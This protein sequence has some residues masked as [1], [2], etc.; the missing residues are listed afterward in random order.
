MESSGRPERRVPRPDD[1]EGGFAQRAARPV[2]GARAVVGVG[3]DHDDRV[4]RASPRMVAL[5]APEVGEPTHRDPVG[6][7]K[8][9]QRAGEARGLLD[10]E[11]LLGH[12]EGR[13][14]LAK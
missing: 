14:V 11:H 5:R 1:H 12:A 7:E 8:A 9:D 13:A 4:R 6:L 10:N 3:R 2:T